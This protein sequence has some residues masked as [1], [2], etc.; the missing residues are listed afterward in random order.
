MRFQLTFPEGWKTQNGASA[1]V[2]V[3]PNQDAIVQLG[4]AGKASPQEAANQFLSQQGVQAGNGSTQSI[5]GNPAATSYFQAQTEQGPIAGVV[6]FIS[7]GGQTFGLLG[8]SGQANFNSYDPAFRQVIGSFQQLRD[9]S[10]LSVKPNRVEL[11]RL[12]RAMSLEEFNRQYPSNIPIEELAIINEV[13]NASDQ[14]PQGRTVK[15]VTGGRTV[16]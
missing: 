14:I 7:Y 5:N 9:Q 15:R 10:K 2:G 11:V 1:V 8:Y 13:E 4:L 6:S 3:S 16:S 12:S